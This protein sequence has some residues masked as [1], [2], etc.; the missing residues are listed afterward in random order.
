VGHHSGELLI[1]LIAA[2]D[3]LEGLEDVAR[4]WME[5]W[6]EL[7]GVGLNLQPQPT[8]VLMGPRTRTV[9]GRGWLRDRFAGIGLRIAA[10]TF[11]QV[12]APQAE[13]VVP[14][15]QEALGN[16]TGLLLDAY[17]GIG[18]FSLPLAAM[19]WRVHGLEQQQAAVELARQNAADN[20]LDAMAGFEAAPVAAV[21]AERLPGVDALLVD[22]P[23]KGLER[24]TLAAIRAHPP[25][26]LLYLSCDP[27]TLA[28]DLALLCGTAKE[29]S[30]PP[31][32]AAGSE[33]GPYRVTLVQPFDFFPNTTHVE[34]LV[35]LERR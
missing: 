35:V 17:C 31:A 21:L 9:L 12:N 26:K 19:G 7:V 25:P 28:R 13:R 33:A 30:A 24:S 3:H 20:G 32:G 14:V 5:R 29:A 10:D 27:A 34:T 2:H 11:F 8:N 4:G 6:P 15:M 22:P 1:T 23:R 18:T 16:S